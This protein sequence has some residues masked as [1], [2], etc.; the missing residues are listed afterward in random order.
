MSSFLGLWLTWPRT[1]EHVH[2]PWPWPWPWALN[3]V[4]GPWLMDHGA[5]PIGMIIIFHLTVN[6]ASPW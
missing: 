6:H 2:G 4:H 3:T 1:M 5:W